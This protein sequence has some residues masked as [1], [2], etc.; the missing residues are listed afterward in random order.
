MTASYWLG[1]ETNA[2][3]ANMDKYPNLGNQY[4]TMIK[5]IVEEMTSIGAVVVLDLHWND[6]DIK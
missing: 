2:A 6:D 1:I 3:K 5:K 4:Q